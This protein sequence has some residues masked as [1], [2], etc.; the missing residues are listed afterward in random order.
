MKSRGKNL[1]EA[2]IREKLALVDRWRASGVSM[3]AWAQGQGLDVAVL[4]AAAGY[5]GRWRR[6]LAGRPIVRTGAGSGFAPVKKVADA[7]AVGKPEISSEA[8]RLECAGVVMYWPLSRG[9]ELAQWL[10][11]LKAVSP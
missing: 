9:V 1:S 4:R 2:Q 11:S 5:E 7:V 10:Q 6:K 8:V 3:T